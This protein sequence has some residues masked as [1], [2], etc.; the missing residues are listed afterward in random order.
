MTAQQIARIGSGGDGAEQQLLNEQGRRVRIVGCFTINMMRDHDV[1]PPHAN[2][3]DEVK[4]SCSIARPSV[5]RFNAAK[6]R[7]E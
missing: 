1:G 4:F 6:D 2:L 5:E 3:S 7:P